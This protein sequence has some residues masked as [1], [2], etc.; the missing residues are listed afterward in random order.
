MLSYVFMKMLEMRPR[1]YDRQLDRISRGRIRAVKEA[2]TREIPTGSSVLEIGCGTGEL[3]SM[4][5]ERG[6]TVE[7]FDVN[8]AMVE[9]AQARIEAEDL[10]ERLRVRQM[11]VDGMD[12]FPDA[13]FDAV[14]ATLVFSELSDDERRFAFAHAARVLKVGGVIMI[15]DEVVPRTPFNRAAHALIRVPLVA[16]TYLVSG[17]STSPIADLAG[18]LKEAGFFI[19]K[20]ERSR[21]DAFALVRGRRIDKRRGRRSPDDPGAHAPES[22]KEEQ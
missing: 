16:V 12:G 6:C 9:R 21:R 11:G 1:S 7:G 14:V 8:P 20:E 3:A 5:V 22:R 2:V 15:A 10:G 13:T 4:L 18:E 17:D 19:E